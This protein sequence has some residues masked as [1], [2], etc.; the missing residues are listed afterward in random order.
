MLD[1]L[2]GNEFD[3][4][5]LACLKSFSEVNSM[6]DNSKN[7]ELDSRDLLMIGNSVSWEMLLIS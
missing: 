4:A 2:V 6:G 5:G 1:D 7:R 3:M